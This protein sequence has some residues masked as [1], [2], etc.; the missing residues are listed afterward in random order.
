MRSPSATCSPGRFIEDD[1]PSDQSGNLLIYDANPVRSLY[2]NDVLFVLSRCQFLARDEKLTLT[3]LD[4]GYPSGHRGAIHVYVK[5][6]QKDTD[7]C[8]TG[9]L[10]FYF[11]HFPVGRRDHIGPGRGRAVGI[12]KEI[13]TEN[14]EDKKGHC[15]KRNSGQPGRQH[16]PG[17]RANAVKNAVNNHLTSILSNV[18]A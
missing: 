13:K 17:K 9:F 7:A 5:H 6:I 11:H 15:E 18:S 2:S 12:T 16:T 3:I 1:S 8:Q 4:I 10:R 14:A